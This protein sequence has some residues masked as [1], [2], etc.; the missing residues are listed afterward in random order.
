MLHAFLGVPHARPGKDTR[1]GFSGCKPHITPGSP[2]RLGVCVRHFPSVI[3]KKKKKK[4]VVVR[5]LHAFLDVSGGV[6]D[7]QYGTD[8]VLGPILWNVGYDSILRF[9]LPIG[10]SVTC[11]ADNTLLM[12]YADSF[13]EARVRAE[14]GPP[15]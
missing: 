13:E 2:P 7:G 8:A 12:A 1:R 6:A 10:C 9:R 14:M 15:L 3:K 4:R 11:Y 5:R